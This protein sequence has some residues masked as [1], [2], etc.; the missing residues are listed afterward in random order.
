[1]YATPVGRDAVDR[2][3][4]ALG[5]SRRW[6][7]NPVVR[8]LPLGALERIAGKR[9]GPDFMDALLTL[10]NDDPG[11]LPASRGPVRRT[12]WKEAV[13][14]QVYPRSFADSDGD[15]IGDLRGIIEHLDHFTALGVDCLWLSPIFASPN[16][17]NGYDVSD[18]RAVMAEMGTLDDLD[19]LI[20][21]CHERGMRIILDLV[22]NHTSDQHAWFRAARQDPD[23]PF[24]DYYFLRPGDP[25]TPP[26]NWVSFFSGPAWRWLDDAKRWALH[27][28]AN[29]QLDLNWENPAV[30][31]EVAQIVRWWMDRG[32]DGF[33]LDVINYISKRHGLPDGNDFIGDLMGFHG[34]E[35]YFHGP[36]LH[37]YL[38]EL[39][40]N[41][42]VRADVAPGTERP[43]GDA[44]GVM[45]GETPGIG[46]ET[47][48]LLTNEGRRELDLIFNFDHL[49]NPGKVRW[50]DYLYDLNFLKSH[51]V[52]YQSRLSNAEWMSIFWDNHDNPRM[53]SKV[54]PSGQHRDAVAKA[55]ATIQLLMRGT[56]FLYQGQEIA[57]VNQAFPD[58]T[59]LR[60]IE[61]INKLAEEE[62]A[63]RNGL[64]VVRAGSRDHPRTPMRWDATENHGFTTGE[65]WIG[66]HEES[67][68]YTV[69]EQSGD[70][71][72]VL[73]FYRQLIAL[74]RKNKALTIGSIE[75]VE[76][77]RRNYFG[78]IREHDG[79]RW[80]VEVNLSEKPTPRPTLDL[81]STTV[82][83]SADR[84]RDLAPYE[85]HLRRRI[86]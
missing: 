86:S 53:V 85:V 19:E 59:A 82:I 50:D 36:R 56:P 64:A 58:A 32:I 60:D 80:L 21:G 70:P 35:Q 55:L 9:L 84:T 44:V 27:L 12:W 74:R 37:E 16:Q 15:G 72:S 20:R 4:L 18:Y 8:R 77:G 42:F 28:F 66:F 78:W 46:I 24:G 2:L 61:S 23:G 65:P 45:I 54:D 39:R 11:P 10:L 40:N 47:G 22:V 38:A 6:V 75:F 67:T 71:D 34:V 29:G 5:R 43:G 17:D 62:L 14:Y 73:N 7:D 48:R 51:Y 69:A 30:R 49:D 41:G 76:P 1:M 79:D 63:G 81:T 68:G 83:G 33:R 57:A 25:A 13:F 3:L 26:N 52:D 31:A